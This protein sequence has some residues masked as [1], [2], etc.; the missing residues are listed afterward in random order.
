MKWTS[1]PHW[2]AYQF[3]LVRTRQHQRRFER[4][5]CQINSKFTDLAANFVG[6]IRGNSKDPSAK[7]P[8]AEIHSRKSIRGNPGNRGTL[9]KRGADQIQTEFLNSQIS[10]TSILIGFPN[11]GSNV[12]HE[13]FWVFPDSCLV[14]LG[15]GKR[16]AM[17]Q[18]PSRL[19]VLRRP[20]TAP[21]PPIVTV[22]FLS[23]FVFGVTPFGDPWS[24]GTQLR[25]LTVPAGDF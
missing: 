16:R 6:S 12:P 7:N 11:R 13:L 25:G 14:N 2:N 19:S 23:R 3:A 10:G 22:V 9:K 15:V 1:S 18:T 21:S 20:T 8:F 17:C 4:R 5:E 24:L